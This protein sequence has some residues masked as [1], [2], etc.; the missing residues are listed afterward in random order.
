MESIKIVLVE[1]HKIVR[2]GTRQLLELVDDF[3][4]IGEAADGLEALELVERLHP[5]VV[6][7]DI[8]L[9]RLNGIEAARQ[10][11]QA[12]PDTEILILSAYEDDCYI[13]PLLEAGANGYLLKTAS[14][15]ELE[16]AIRAVR[17]GETALDPHVAHKVVS[18]LKRKQLYR[19]VE[20]CEGLTERELDVLRGVMHGKSNKEIGRM[21]SISAGTV[22]VHLRN[23]FGKMNVSGRT[24]AVTMAISQGWLVPQEG[25]HEMD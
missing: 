10:I 24:E 19:T 4:V 17:R 14:G 7:M 15:V 9:P 1:D 3:S 5:E 21:L 23:I 6:V 25:G 20:M 18:R 13:F 12:H 16:M 8:R 22:Q 11:K 2:E